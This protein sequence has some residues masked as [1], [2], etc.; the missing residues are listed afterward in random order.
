[1]EGTANWER[2]GCFETER[3]TAQKE[4]KIQELKIQKVPGCLWRSQ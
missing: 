4:V 2:A 1:M 3:T